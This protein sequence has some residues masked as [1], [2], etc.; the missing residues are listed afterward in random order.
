MA[1]FRATDGPGNRKAF[2]PSRLVKKKKKAKASTVIFDIFSLQMLSICHYNHLNLNIA[3]E[4]T[5]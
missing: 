2:L 4:A 1:Y 5:L 3:A